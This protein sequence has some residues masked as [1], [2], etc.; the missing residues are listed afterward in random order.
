[1]KTADLECTHLIVSKSGFLT[2]ARAGGD[3]AGGCMGGGQ[4]GPNLGGILKIL[5]ALKLDPDPISGLRH[6]RSPPR[7]AMAAG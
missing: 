3:L 5:G 4:G 7:S 6:A 2:R 1:M